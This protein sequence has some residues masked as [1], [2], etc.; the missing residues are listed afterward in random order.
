LSSTAPDPTGDGA[1]GRTDAAPWFNRI[2]PATLIE[3]FLAQPPVGFAVPAGGLGAPAF[4]ADF[5]L[6]TTMEPQQR[7][8][9]AALPFWRRAQRWLSLRTC[10]VGTTVT[11]Y[12][13]LPSDESAEDF[14]ARLVRMAA[15][16]PLLIVKDLPAG[17]E[18]VGA[19]A[20]RHS[21][22]VAA[23]CRRA[24]FLM[25][26]GQALAFVPIDFASTAAFLDRM[27]RA[28][29]KDIKR[30]LRSTA[31]LD[32]EVLPTGAARLADPA[33]LDEL[34]QLYRNVYA[35]SDI[36][37]DLL[38]AAFF[39]A[40]LRDA[41]PGGV[42]FLYRAAG[43]LIGYNLC[44]EQNGLLLDK[45][46]GF[47]YPA[48]REHNL[49][50]VSWFHNLAYAVQRGLH[51]YVAGWTD[52]EIKRHLG[53][54]FTFTRHAVYFRNPWLRRLLKPFKRYFEADAQWRQRTR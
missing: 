27:P 18:L 51:V 12:A 30:K 46:V 3:H 6:T 9:L 44:F 54:S 43:R 50:V 21:A 45:Y 23:A 8:R 41:T 35:Q 53:A 4:V 5:D 52:P 11:E 47:V 26:E 24:G 22:A 29:R 39:R 48:A 36:H 17:P 19:A 25:V 1:G 40:V 33:L 38:S 31:G 13:L 7:R 49:Y 16:Y 2:E 28:R 20:Q 42:L 34:Y 15:D 14:V 32:I 37:F 10:F